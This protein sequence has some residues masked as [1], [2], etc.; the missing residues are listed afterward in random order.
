MSFRVGQIVNIKFQDR[1]MAKFPKM[2]VVEVEL[3]IL[4]MEEVT[5]VYMTSNGEIKLQAFPANILI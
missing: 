3:N 4:E 1:D 5:C 2:F